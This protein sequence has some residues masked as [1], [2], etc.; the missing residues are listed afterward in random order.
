M[1]SM[2]IDRRHFLI[3]TALTL[4]SASRAFAG[5]LPLAGDGSDELVG[6]L[7]AACRRP[8]GS[9]SVV[10]LTLDGMI[11]RELPLQ[12]RGHDIA[13]DRASGRAVVFARRPGS[14]ALGFDVRGK[15]EPVLFTTPANRHFY[16]HGTF[17]HDGR[18]LYATEHDAE[19]RQGLVGVYDATGGY[20][21]I[22]EIPTY[23]IGPHE[24]IL[25]PDGRTFAVANG[26]IETHVE[27]GREKHNVEAMEPSLAFI[28]SRTGDLLAQHKQSRDLHKLS[29]RHVAA[30]ARGAVWF[31]CQWEGE[32]AN[33]PELVGCAAL[34]K[35]LRIIEPT[36]PRGAHLAGYIGAVAIDGDGRILAASAP[37][38]GRI[39]YVDTESGAVVGE[40]QIMDS[41]GITGISESGFAMS[42]G[43]GVLQSEEPD[44][45]HLTV[46]SFPGRAFDNHLRLVR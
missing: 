26:G 43:M 40:T 31:G 42:S 24:L 20:K 18:L 4:A 3:G 21:R 10:I 25:M 12:G 11:V 7:I 13:L 1:N 34:D 23:G 27:T 5:V 28:D 6:D 16:G 30:D 15:A 45:S 44:H 35:P 17:S 37:R 38:A 2:A 36:T 22:G 41:C 32:T 14:F 33:S 39:I 46:A 29:I 19:T 8:D 9:Y